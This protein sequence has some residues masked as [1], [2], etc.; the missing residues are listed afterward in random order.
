MSWQQTCTLGI[1]PETLS[2][3]RDNHLPATE[4]ARISRH[5]PDCD[6]CRGTL[7]QFDVVAHTLWRQGDLDPGNR[8]W[9]GVQSQIARGGARRAGFAAYAWRGAGATLA[10]LLVVTLFA[11]ALRNLNHFQSA[12]S[13]VD[14]TTTQMTPTT[15]GSATP[16]GTATPTSLNQPSATQSWGPTA[17]TLSFDLPS[18]NTQVFQASAITPDGRLLLGDMITSTGQGTRPQQLAGYFT[19]SATGQFTSIG[20]SSAGD[21]VCCQPDSS[22]RYLMATDS[23]APGATGSSGHVRYWIYDLQTH[24]IRMVAAGADYQ[25]ISNGFVD[26]GLLVLSTGLGIEIANLASQTIALYGP[27]ANTNTTQST[28]YAY[29]WPYMVYDIY[30]SARSTNTLHAYNFQTRADSVIAAPGTYSNYR[31]IGDTLFVARQIMQGSQI[32]GYQV[33]EMDHFATAGAQSRLIATYPGQ[34][35]GIIGANDRLIAFQ[36]TYPWVWDRG[37]NHFVALPTTAIPNGASFA[38]AL[39]GNEFAFFTNTKPSSSALPGPQQVTFY[40][41]TKLPLSGNPP[42]S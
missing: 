36:G 41:T 7:T 24:K 16:P 37:E 18:S 34:G 32:Q 1:T 39:S 2:S 26:H 27:G 14:S 3:W 38:E 13:V 35:D 22:G 31:V 29:K 10:V 21:P 28:I 8:V 6:A 15:I 5:I 25:M 33:Y 40:D 9:R 20:L 17:A 30:D 19:A 23:T 12:T 11:I 42:P 4:K